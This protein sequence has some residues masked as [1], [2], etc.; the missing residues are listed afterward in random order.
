M[1]V[2]VVGVNYVYCGLK[3][4][5]HTKKTDL[6]TTVKKYLLKALLCIL[7]NCVLVEAAGVEQFC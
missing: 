2:F 5:I 6:L 4:S 7:L 1:P 3:S